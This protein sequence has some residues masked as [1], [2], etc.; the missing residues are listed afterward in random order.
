MMMYLYRILIDHFCWSMRDDMV[1]LSTVMVYQFTVRGPSQ[2]YLIW[3]WHE[4]IHGVKELPATNP[5]QYPLAILLMEEIL[6]QLI[7]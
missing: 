1:C 3:L 7:W 4:V 6:H 5:N 2:N